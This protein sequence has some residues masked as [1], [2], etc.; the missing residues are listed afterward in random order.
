[1]TNYQQ[2]FRPGSFRT[3]NVTAGIVIRFPI[4]NAT[5][6]ARAE[7]AD[8]A[9]LSARKE[10]DNAKGELSSR[11]AKLQ[12]MVRQLSAA[13]DVAQVQYE[14]AEAQLESAQARM[15]G[16]TATLRE[17]QDASLQ[18]VQSSGGL[19]DS[20]LDLERAQLQL[21]QANG[22]LESWSAAAK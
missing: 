1:L 18:A 8:A 2:F 12:S 7:A 21:L 20:E 16:P 11:I 17:L 19:M 15:Q 4:L 13:R 22:Q 9:A 5:Q 14:L 10:A 6:R 3:S